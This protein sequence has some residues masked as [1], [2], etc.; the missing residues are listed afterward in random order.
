MPVAAAAAA[1]PCARA[2]GG[3]HI[4]AATAAGR[5]TSL[6][7]PPLPLPPPLR[8]GVGVGAAI[9]LGAKKTRQRRP[10][11]GAPGVVWRRQGA[12]GGR[13]ARGGPRD[14]SPLALLRRAS[15]QRLFLMPRSNRKYE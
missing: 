15:Q 5:R 2:G 4:A 13:A 11:H 12:G 1:P 6:P 10:P 14:V 9:R 3:R 7:L 8:G